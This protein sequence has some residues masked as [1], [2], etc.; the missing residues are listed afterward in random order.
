MTT[1]DET[2][3]PLHGVATISDQIYVGETLPPLP[4]QFALSLVIFCTDGDAQITMNGN[5]YEFTEKDLVF[6]A[7]G[8]YVSDLSPN[9][10]K[11]TFVYITR[12]ELYWTAIFYR[13]IDLI[14]N[15]RSKPI[16]HLSPT[17]AEIGEEYLR[18]AQKITLSANNNPYRTE[19]LKRLVDS[20]IYGILSLLDTNKGSTERCSKVFV[21]FIELIEKG[22]GTIRTV[23]E[24][25]SRLCISSKHLAY[26]VKEN[27]GMTPSE[28]IDIVTLQAIL[29]RLRNTNDPLKTIASDLGFPNASSFGTYFRHHIGLS[30]AAYR[31]QNH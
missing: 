6:V 1:I 18:L 16:L 17:S 26:V 20:F 10:A 27:S 5:R 24:V 3:I 13:P 8:S 11:L 4:A 28:W 15:L 12:A 21:S 30:P 31:K 23:N 25:A 22:H 29:T 2:N 7:P 19:A 14:R 9:G